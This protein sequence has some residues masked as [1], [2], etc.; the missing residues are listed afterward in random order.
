MDS[1]YTFSCSV[2]AS[3]VCLESISEQ[4]ASWRSRSKTDGSEIKFPE[5]FE[6]VMEHG[7]VLQ[8]NRKSTS[9]LYTYKDTV[10]HHNDRLGKV[11]IRQKSGQ[12]APMTLEK[13]QRS[14]ARVGDPMIKRLLLVHSTNMAFME[15]KKKAIVEGSHE[16]SLPHSCRGNSKRV[17]ESVR[18]RT[19]QTNRDEG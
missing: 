11:S 12:E 14:T 16:T 18:V 6:H 5:R 15:K 7:S 8:L 10:V 19:D 2:K 1:Q 3:Q 4:P 9:H 17:D 13:L